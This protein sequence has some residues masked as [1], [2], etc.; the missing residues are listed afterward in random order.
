MT[1]IDKQVKK[2]EPKNINKNLVREE[3][4]RVY[5]LW[6]LHYYKTNTIE[7]LNINNKK[8]YKSLISKDIMGWRLCGDFNR[9]SIAMYFGFKL[10]LDI[11][12]TIVVTYKIKDINESFKEV[13]YNISYVTIKPKEVNLLYIDLL[14]KNDKQ[15]DAIDSVFIDQ[16]CPSGSMISRDGEYRGTFLHWNSLQL[17]LTKNIKAKSIYEYIL[18]YFTKVLKERKYILLIE[19]LFP[20]DRIK[21]QFQFETELLCSSTKI[22]I[23]CITWFTFYYSYY[24]GFISN[25]ING[26][27]KNLMLKYKTHDIPFFKSLWVKFDLET[28]EEFRYICSNNIRGYRSTSFRISE[29]MKFGQKLIPLNL[30]DAQYPFDL[31]YS[32]WKELL[33]GNKLSDLVINGISNGFAITNSW[34]LIKHADVALFDNPSQYD[35][36]AKSKIGLKIA[37][38]LKQANIYAYN[39]INMFENDKDNQDDILSSVSG[40][41]N[42][43]NITSWLSNE[44]KVLQSKIQDS[45]NH[46]KENIIMSNITLALISEYLGKTFYDSI[47]ISSTS[48][49]YNKLT[50]NMLS[51]DN[52][53]NFKKY[54]FEICYNLYCLNSKV[55]LIHG[56]LHLNNLTL[57]VLVYTKNIIVKEKDPKI[58]FVLDEDH[59]YIFNHNLYDICIIDY[60]RSIIDID[61]T[62]DFKIDH[63]S[64]MFDIISNKDQFKNKQIQ[65]LLNYL[66]TSKVEYKEFSASLDPIVQH[67]YKEY[68]KILTT[69]DLF[70]FTSKFLD[71]FKSNL[72]NTTPYTKCVKLISDLNKSA[73]Y[74]L[75]HVLLK[76][77]QEQNY[78]EVINMEWP[79]LTIIKD[80]FQDNEAA[81][82]TDTN[83][84]SIIDVYN[85]NHDIKY[86][87]SAFKY[88]PPTLKEKKKL[89]NGKV[90]ESTKKE[91]DLR[92]FAIKRRKLYEV[93]TLKNFD[94]LNIIIKRQMEK[95]L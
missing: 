55:G 32:P 52:Y 18:K 29:K 63:I 75:T 37:N 11:V 64:N 79:I 39:S 51:Q 8:L 19:I 85:Y 4:V 95:H 71:I 49:Y 84:D 58:L 12:Q 1:N 25:N 5:D 57:D 15:K 87:L 59:Q 89:I 62:D 56:D 36:I 28:I 73:E 31:E 74:Y 16:I 13:I 69:L 30:M 93:K 61:K 24:F 48:K 88:F 27:F 67:H 35:R 41:V 45:I 86:S 66:Y 34:F 80:I 26:V 82:F 14:E 3:I 50:N 2:I 33:I 83:Y 21:E 90:I 38:V 91:F 9:F 47:F 54:M 44:F 77:I 68:F 23:F 40:T 10:V 7:T 20:T 70:N 60:S 94:T 17:V 76:L 53:E 22:E 81:N 78:D 6:R 92:N 65:V 46:D 72:L 42:K 43:N